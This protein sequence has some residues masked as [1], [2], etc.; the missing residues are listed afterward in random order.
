VTSVG[1][2]G[3]ALAITAALCVVVE[4]GQPDKPDGSGPDIIGTY[5]CEGTNPDGTAYRGI[6]Q[7]A[8]Q[9][10]AYLILWTLPPDG[11][12][13]GLGMLRGGVLAVSYF[14]GG[15]GL[16]VYNVTETADGIRLDGKWT[17]LAAK[18]RTFSETLKK[19][20]GEIQQLPPLRP[21]SNQTVPQRRRIAVGP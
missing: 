12:Y 3:W 19:M 8:R 18:G 15:M 10:D 14:S 6:V 17:V 5:A 7:I 16:I 4:A 11:R 21:P 13:L 9:G 1:S 20:P 2:I